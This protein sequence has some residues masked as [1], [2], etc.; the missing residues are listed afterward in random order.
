[1]D[2]NLLLGTFSSEDDIIKVTQA[3]REAGFTIHDVYTPYAVHGLDKAMG[4]KPSWL[5]FACF[6]FA[7]AGLLI[8]LVAQFWIGSIDWPV[9]VGGKPFNSLPAYLP[10]MFEL[11]VLIGGLG[12][13]FTM[14]VVTKLYPGKVSKSIHPGVTNNRFALAIEKKDSSFDEAK[15]KKLWA[16]H[17]VL[18]MEY[19]SENFS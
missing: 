15:I 11:M 4:L 16:D 9:N 3:S 12:V 2:Q 8:G 1:M 19:L 14:F 7:F 5:T 13:V 6:T 18:E 17:N 10:V